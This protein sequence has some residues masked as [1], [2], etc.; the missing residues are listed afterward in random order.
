MQAFTRYKFPLLNLDVFLINYIDKILQE[1]KKHARNDINNT[2]LNLYHC[3]PYIFSYNIY[4]KSNECTIFLF[5]LVVYHKSLQVLN[6]VYFL[7]YNSL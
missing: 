5:K 2:V 1:K 7:T 3:V 6:V 4:K